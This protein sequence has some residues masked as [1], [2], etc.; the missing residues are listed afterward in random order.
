MTNPMTTTGDIC[1]ERLRLLR[2]GSSGHRL[3]RQR[4]DGSW[5]YSKLGFTSD[6]GNGDI[7]WSV[8]ECWLA[9]GGFMSG[10]INWHDH[11]E[12]DHRSG[13]EPSVCHAGWHNWCCW[14]ECIS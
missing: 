6:S 12:C 2:T 8:D 5:W 10:Y 4:S 7:G 14:T 3:D 9:D 13:S 1:M 11:V